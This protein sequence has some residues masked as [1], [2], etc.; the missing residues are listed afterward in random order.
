MA[1][2]PVSLLPPLLS[3][4]PFPSLSLS[5]FSWPCSHPPCF[6]QPDTQETVLLGP[7][8]AGTPTHQETPAEAVEPTSPPADSLSALL[9]APAPACGCELGEEREEKRWEEVEVGGS[10]GQEGLSRPPLFSLDLGPHQQWGPPNWH[11]GVIP[12]RRTPRATIW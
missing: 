10:K 7:R 5:P 1:N 12:T 4:F 3:S 8:L 9:G 2:L 11:T 6:T